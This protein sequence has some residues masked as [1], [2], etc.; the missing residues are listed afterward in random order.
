MNANTFQNKLAAEPR[1]GEVQNQFWITAG[2]PILKKKLF[3]FFAFE[4]YRQSIASTIITNVPPAFLRPGYNGNAGVDF[5]LVGLLAPQQFPTGLPIYQPGTAFC[6]DGGPAT[7]C[8]SNHVAQKPFANDMLPASQISPTALAVLKYIPLPNIAGAQDS[9]SGNNYIGHNP[10]LYDYNQPQIRVDYNLSDKTK[11][12]SYFLYWHGTEYRSGNGLNGVAATGNINWI[13]QN[14]V[15]TQD[16]THVFNPTLIGDFKISFNRF[17]ESSPDGDLTQ[18]TNPSTIGLGMPLPGTTS[19]QYL[20]ELTVGDGWGTGFVGGTNAVFGNESNLDVTNN[21]TVDADLTKTRGAHTLEFGGEFDEF[22]YANPGS[23]GHANGDFNFNSSWTQ[24]NPHNAACYGPAG[25]ACTSNQQNGSSLASL[26]LGYPATGGIDWNRTIFEGQP[27]WAGYFQDNWRVNHRLTLN[28]GMRYDVQRGLRERHNELNRGLCMTCVNPIGNTAA[29][30]A[31]VANGANAAAWTAA[32]IN[33]ASLT[34]VLG[35]I[36]FAGT[37]GQ[38]RDAYNTDWSNIGPRFGFAFAIDSKTVLRGGYGVIYSYGLEGGT[39]IGETQTT[40]YTASVDGGNTPTNNFQTGSPFASGLVAPSGSSLGLETN[41]GNGGE[42]LDFPNRKIPREQLVSFGLQRE[43]PGRFILDATYAGNFSSRLRTFLWVNGTASRSLINAVIANPQIFNQQVPNPYYGVPGISGPGQCGTGTTV[44]AVTLLLP[45]PQYCSPGGD[46][47]VGDN[48]SPQ[49]RNWYDGLEVKLNRH[50][51]NSAGKGLS[52]QVAYTYSKTINGDGYQNGWPYQ[53]QFQEHWIAGT[54]RTHVFSLTSVWDLPIGRGGLFY[55]SPNS[56]TGSLINDWTL[57]GVF[58]YQSGTPV[59]VS[60]GY[61]YVCPGQ[62]YRP[63]NGTSVGQGHWFSDNASCW[64]SLPTY[65]LSYL[66][67]T[68]AQ[69]R[70]PTIPS[71][72]LSLQKSTPIAEGKIFNLR[73]DAF[74]A[75]NTVLF[76]GPNTN[77]GAGPATFT[78]GTGWSGFG[79][80]S[81]IQQNF[82]RIL[83]VSGKLSF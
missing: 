15:A 43:L 41:L 65:G 77:P 19:A 25:D 80:V 17:L 56:V 45:L 79:T 12:Y 39:T 26:Y 38:S 31:N 1:D 53:D 83:Q 60:T 55:N 50:V 21:F 52:T 11:L 64:Q 28:F 7:A 30:Q 23:I 14:W 67:A 49:G 29:Y 9:V 4:G 61:D 44:E 76:P 72:D 54:D 10:D 46:G 62:S 20:P 71:L 78:P 33:P 32:G 35:G 82:P 69:V 2:G 73:L 16:F 51:T 81:E 40:N 34:Q 18:Q 66:S 6:L 63:T 74:N 27:V 36:Q 57:S 3:G 58:N 48:N 47:L 37:D 8:N 68:T 24:L 70:N 75:I 13:Q 59:G 5:S 22:Q 42:T